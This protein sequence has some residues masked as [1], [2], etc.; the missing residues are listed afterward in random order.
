MKW[1]FP[2]YPSNWDQIRKQVYKRDDYTCQRCY[3]K[4]GPY[5]NNILHCAHIISK[6]EGGSDDP[7]NLETVCEECH[8]E[9]HP[10]LL[11]NQ[12]IRKRH[13]KRLLYS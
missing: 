9:E 2:Q 7:E 1:N 6:S 11:N 8:I 4:G 13:L 3:S 12:I 5:G 10:H